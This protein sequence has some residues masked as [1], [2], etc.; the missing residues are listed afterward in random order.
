MAALAVRPELGGRLMRASSVG[1]MHGPLSYDSIFLTLYFIV[2][3]GRTFYSQEVF[4]SIS[5]PQ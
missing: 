5:D 4:C 3:F 1:L 2:H